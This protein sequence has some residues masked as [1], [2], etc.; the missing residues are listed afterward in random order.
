M[1]FLQGQTQV[2]NIALGEYLDRHSGLVHPMI[3]QRVA[4]DS[5]VSL[6]RHLDAS[7][8]VGNTA[9]VGERVPHGVCAG[10]ASTEECRVNV[11]QYKFHG[12]PYLFRVGLTRVV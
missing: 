3:R 7:E 5:G 8:P 1:W 11:E 12:A 2:G 4:Q 10:S 6:A 9:Q